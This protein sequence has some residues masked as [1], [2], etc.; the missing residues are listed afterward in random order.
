MSFFPRLYP[1]IDFY[2]L[3]RVKSEME[4]SCLEALW[5]DLEKVS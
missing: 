4:T 1:I 3:H 2:D 5:T